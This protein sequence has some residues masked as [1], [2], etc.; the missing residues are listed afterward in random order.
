[1]E[2]TGLSGWLIAS[3]MGWR[4]EAYFDDLADKLGAGSQDKRAVV[5]PPVAGL[6]NI[7]PNRPR[8]PPLD[9][10]IHKI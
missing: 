3:V 4:D 1:M 2:L 8:M 7:A 10:E 5:P 6:M 9:R